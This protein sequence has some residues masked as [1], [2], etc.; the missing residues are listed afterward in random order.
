VP[1]ELVVALEPIRLDAD[2]G[3][4]VGDTDQQIAALGI[5]E[6][7]DGLQHSV[8]HAFVV[9][10]VLLQAPTKSGFELE[11]F[12]E[13]YRAGG[14]AVIG[15]EST[16]DALHAGQVDTLAI[17]ASPEQIVGEDIAAMKWSD[18]P[19]RPPRRS[20]SSKILRCCSPS[21]AWV[22]VCAISRDPWTVEKRFTMSKK[23]NVHPDHYKVAGRSRQGESVVHERERQKRN[24]QANVPKK[25]RTARRPL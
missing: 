13:Q 4:I 15:I 22:R 16:R 8:R 25:R 5:Q 17:A 11:R 19:G 21:E 7:G 18:L 12:L 9:L 14:L 2:D 20:V 1:H 24:R 3:A 23:S 10:L 6:R